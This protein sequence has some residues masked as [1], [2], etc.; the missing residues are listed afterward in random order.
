MIGEFE[1]KFAVSSDGI[2]FGL[3]RAQPLGR[4]AWAVEVFVCEHDL[5]I[6]VGVGGRGNP[7]PREH[8]IGAV[9]VMALLRR[10]I[11]STSCSAVKRQS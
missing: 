8:V 7:G 11:R 5:P 6:T 2:D 9:H 10:L 1:D 3:D 4:P